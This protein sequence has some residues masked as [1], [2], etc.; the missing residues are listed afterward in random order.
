[1]EADVTQLK[2]RKSLWDYFVLGFLLQFFVTFG[3]LIWWSMCISLLHPLFHAPVLSGAVTWEYGYTASWINVPVDE[4]AFLLCCFLPLPL[5]TIFVSGW[6]RMPWWAWVGATVFIGSCLGTLTY[7]SN[8]N[9]MGI[10][11]AVFVE[12]GWLWACG[13]GF[14]FRWV[15]RVLKIG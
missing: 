4:L 9:Y 5:V 13:L 6:L 15:V 2:R 8:P 11:Y 14:F 1:M 10:E 7:L 3:M 12:S